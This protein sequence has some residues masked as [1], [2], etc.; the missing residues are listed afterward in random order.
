ML[1]LHA[2][3]ASNPVLRQVVMGV[4]PASKYPWMRSRASECRC[5]QSQVVPL[6][7]RCWWP[8]DPPR[9][10]RR[11]W[12]SNWPAIVIL[13]VCFG[14]TGGFQWMYI[15]WHTQVQG[16]LKLWTVFWK[17]HLRSLERCT[18][19]SSSG[20]RRGG[21]NAEDPEL[22]DPQSINPEQS[23]PLLMV[24]LFHPSALAITSAQVVSG[25]HT[26]HMFSSIVYRCLL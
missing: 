4:Q 18:L 23:R 11:P 20:H 2:F 25:P 22:Q 19:S 26:S 17:P 15:P 6:H 16:K 3:V 14:K 8:N 1:P 9:R 21:I 10:C 7:D 13:M 24:S 12:P 5:D